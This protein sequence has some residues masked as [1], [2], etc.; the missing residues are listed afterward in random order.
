M[1]LLHFELS[2]VL[3]RAAGSDDIGVVLPFLLPEFLAADEVD[4]AGGPD[5][6]RSA[7]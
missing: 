6:S 1:G 2:I 7:A 3:G 4:S 5:S